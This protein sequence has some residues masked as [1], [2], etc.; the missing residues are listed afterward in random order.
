MENIRKGGLK[1]KEVRWK[2]ICAY[3]ERVMNVY[4]ILVIQ[5]LFASATHIAAKAVI[6]DVDAL[7]LTMLR[8]II[9]AVG[10]GSILV[11]R[12]VR[13]RFD[14]GYRRSIIVLGFLIVLNQYLY[15]YGMKYT[16]AA[17][18]ALLYAL[19]PIFVLVL[20]RFSLTE[21][22]TIQKLIG[23]IIAFIGITVVIF[24]RGVSTSSEFTF[25]NIIILLAVITY[26]LF[27][28]LGKPLVQKFGALSA[29]ASANLAG[30]FLIVPIGFYTTVTFPYEHLHALDWVG[31]FYLGIGTSLIGYL[32][33]Y[34]ALRRID[35]TRLAVFAN[36][37]PI[38]TSILSIL[39]LGATMTPQF[40][41]GGIVT[42]AGVIITQ[43]K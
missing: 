24:E 34:Y 2:Q 37:Q 30:V 35:A 18:G 13:I 22:I 20:S 28:I 3:I 12:G 32:L 29:A 26:A 10:F 4:I 31:I 21:K 15:L 11:V 1:T 19:T 39:F 14:K 42:L 33:W 41:I 25:G 27:T 16:T 9:S 40:I 23:I 43:R 7:T 8:N 6:G 36:G 17:N 5:L 38:V